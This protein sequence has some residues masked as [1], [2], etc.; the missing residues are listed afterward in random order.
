MNALP[1]MQNFHSRG[2]ALEEFCP[3]C[4]HSYESTSLALIHCDLVA[5]VWSDWTECPIKLLDSIF[6]I[7]DIALE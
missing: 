1:T 4:N 3:L 6:D 5:K 7:S 2:V